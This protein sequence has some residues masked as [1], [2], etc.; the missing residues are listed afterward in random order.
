V[1]RRF[2]ASFAALGVVG[3]SWA[4]GYYSR[5]APSAP[6]VGLI[7]VAAVYQPPPFR[8]VAPLRATITVTRVRRATTPA[9][10]GNKG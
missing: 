7:G 3:A 4:G 5:S 6:A 8:F 10:S 2:A 1:R 9:R